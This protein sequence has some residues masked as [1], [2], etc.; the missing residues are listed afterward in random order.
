[1]DRGILVDTRIQRLRHFDEHIN[2]CCRRVVGRDAM[3][4]VCARERE[5]GSESEVEE[6]LLG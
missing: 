2:S 3:A 1:M 6:A 5:G 4:C